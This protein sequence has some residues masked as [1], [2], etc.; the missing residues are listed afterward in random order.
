VSLA[1]ALSIWLA[2]PPPP[3]PDGCTE[4]PQHALMIE[5]GE[6]TAT[7]SVMPAKVTQ[8][9]Y[10]QTAVE[11]I[12]STHGVAPVT[13]PAELTLD[14]RKVAAEQYAVGSD[15]GWLMVLP[16]KNGNLMLGCQSPGPVDAARRTCLPL[17]ERLLLSQNPAKAKRAP[18]PRI[19]GK[20]LEVPPGCSYDGRAEVS[21]ADGAL[22]W[23]PG[24]G[25]LSAFIDELVKKHG[26]HAPERSDAA[27]SIVGKQ[28][29]CYAVQKKDEQDRVLKYLLFGE[30]EATGER[31]Y[32]I[33]DAPL[34]PLPT[35]PRACALMFGRGKR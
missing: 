20:P 24:A 2:A 1:V 5:C 12:K 16:Q 6:T 34:N 31:L 33:C 35:V 26:G 13:V 14:G 23:M 9:E 7:A 28:S 11:G 29:Q 30:T 10:V 21:C 18:L 8:A 4:D 27:C 19:S 25:P 17:L 3:L 32:L 15:F 22:S